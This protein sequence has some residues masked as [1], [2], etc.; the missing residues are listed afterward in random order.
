MSDYKQNLGNIKNLIPQNT[1]IVFITW[2]FNENYTEEMAK[3]NENFLNE[4][5]FNNIE[6]FKVPWSLEIPA[7]IKRIVEK[8][9]KVDLGIFKLTL[10]KASLKLGSI[11]ESKIPES[12]LIIVPESKK[13]DKRMLLSMVKNEAIEGIELVETERA[14]II[15]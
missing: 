6:K 13:L 14:L 4:K 5:W 8:K 9:D 15:K 1:N 3:K 10:K 2:K 7:F 12:C 11:D